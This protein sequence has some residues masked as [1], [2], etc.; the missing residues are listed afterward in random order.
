M[1]LSLA[2]K[3]L[4]P[5]HDSSNKDWSVWRANF[6]GS[7]HSSIDTNTAVS[8]PWTGTIYGPLRAR[9]RETC[10][11]RI[12]ASTRQGIFKTYSREYLV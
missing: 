7:R 5:T 1:K 12:F 10:G 6:S 2:G 9:Y 4:K 3:A 11:K 8:T